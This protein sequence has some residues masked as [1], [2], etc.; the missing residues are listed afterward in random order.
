MPY[1][2]AIDPGDIGRHPAEGG[3]EHQLSHF[4]VC[5]PKVDS[6]SEDTVV[7]GPL[8]FGF[9]ALIYLAVYGCRGRKPLAAAVLD[10]FVDG[11][12]PALQFGGVQELF[13]DQV[14]IV[15]IEMAFRSR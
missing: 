10:G 11:I 15:G 6:L 7:V 13:H 2:H 4:V 1:A 12:P 3:V 9:R 14:P 8:L 5:L